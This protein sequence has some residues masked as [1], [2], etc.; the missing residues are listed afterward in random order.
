MDLDDRAGRNRQ[1]RRNRA[2]ELVVSLVGREAKLRLR[3]NGRGRRFLYTFGLDYRLR[4]FGG[5]SE[6]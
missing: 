6:Q 1:H 2:T 4:D 3:R 5:A